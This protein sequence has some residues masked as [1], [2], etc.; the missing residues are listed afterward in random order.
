MMNKGDGE[1]S[2]FPD[3]VIV[4]AMKAGTTFLHSIL[5]EHPEIY[6]PSQKEPHYFL[7]ANKNDFVVPQG[8]TGFTG[9]IEDETTYRNLFRSKK[10][11]QISGEASVHYLVDENAAKNIYDYNP[12]C[13]VVML[14][15]NPVDRAYSAYTACRSWGVEPRHTF[16]EAIREEMSGERDGWWYA[17]RYLY[18][19][20]YSLH[21]K[22]FIDVFEPRSIFVINFDDLRDNP[23]KV[24]D[25]VC[26]FLGVSKLSEESLT[27]EGRVYATENPTNFF[28]RRIKVVVT[29]AG[30]TKEFVK[31]LL[32]NNLR[33][34]IKY[35]LIDW[36]A[37]AD[38]AKP[39]K[40]SPETR[41]ELD[42]YFVEDQ[43]QLTRILKDSNLRVNA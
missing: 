27:S 26:D 29:G 1:S 36:V 39:E 22:R 3:F 12:N 24:V 13:K 15:R 33:A 43:V 16:E 21:A 18:S 17:F 4:G 10:A 20:L 37:R 30:R 19:G 35:V 2:T 25:D 11:K 7:L 38:A 41:K 42:K 5:S 40:M 9:I 6:M 32:P 34:R 31:W 28:I 8:K 14:L 23:K